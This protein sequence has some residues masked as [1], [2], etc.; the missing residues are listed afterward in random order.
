M[1]PKNNEVAVVETAQLPALAPTP[2]NSITAADI[3]LPK[4]YRGETQS[5]AFKDDLVPKGCIFIASG[6][7]DPEPQVVAEPGDDKG[8]LMHVLDLKKGWSHSVQGED[9]QTWAFEDP[10]RHPDAWV[11]YQYVVALPE[12]DDEIPVKL[13]MTKTSTQTAKRINFLLLKQNGRPPYE[14]AFRLSLNERKAE[15]GGQ[16]FQWYTWQ[17]KTVEADPAN[18]AIAAKVA[19][20]VTSSNNNIETTAGASSAPAI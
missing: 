8:I 15:K 5:N 3:A 9:L 2:A 6:A 16:K 13:L 19:E 10:D 17:A 7:D 4:L 20:L 14:L 1:P 11:T 18:V 12:I